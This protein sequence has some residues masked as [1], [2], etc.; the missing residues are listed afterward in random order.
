MKDMEFDLSAGE[1]TASR[2]ITPPELGKLAAMTVL[3]VLLA[4][5]LLDFVRLRRRRMRSASGR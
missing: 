2:A 1:Q 4:K 5:E 3:G